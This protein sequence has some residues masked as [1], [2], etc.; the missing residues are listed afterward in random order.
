MVR[1]NWWPDPVTHIPFHSAGTKR[2]GERQ[3]GEKVSK[4]E[5]EKESESVVGEKG[6]EREKAKRHL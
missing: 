4:S 6:G 3:K 1:L 2:K 5:R